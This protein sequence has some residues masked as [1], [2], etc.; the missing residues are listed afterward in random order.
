MASALSHITNNLSGDGSLTQG[1][2]LSH[3]PSAT[4]STDAHP[5]MNDPPKRKRGR[6]KGSTKKPDASP[7]EPK[8]K[9][10][11][12]RPRKD[13]LP[14]GSVP[15]RSPVKRSRLGTTLQD[16]YASAAS[17]WGA[18]S[19]I[20]GVS[21]P[22]PPPPPNI[23]SASTSKRTILASEE[24]NGGTDEWSE[25]AY[26]DPDGFLASL[27]NA[28]AAPNPT[29]A[30][31]PT[32]EEAFKM[33]LQSL[34]TNASQQSHNIPSLYSLLKT[35]WLPSSPAYFTIAASASSTRVPMEY[36]FLYWDPLPLLFNGIQCPYCP[37]FLT[38]KGRIR[39]GPIKIYDLEKPFFI[40]GCE[41]ACASTQC[42]TAT[43]PDGRKFASTDS[44]IM[45]ALPKGLRDEFPARLLHYENDAGSGANI[46]N[47]GAMG[48]SMSLWNMVVG[49]F[50]LGLRKSIVLQ[51]MRSIQMGVPELVKPE[52]K[53]EDK[54]P[55]RG[56]SSTIGDV[57][58]KR[59]PSE[60]NKDKKS[61]S[62]ANGSSHIHHAWN[63]GDSQATD[64]PNTSSSSYG[65]GANEGMG[66][67]EFVHPRRQSRPSSAFAQYPYPHYTYF[68]EQTSTPGQSSMGGTSG[69]RGSGNSQLNR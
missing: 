59:R 65:G 15:K 13:G 1:S 21:Y 29:S 30:T 9:R 39:S 32:V 5:P 58:E 12:G 53:D 61:G 40:I 26:T 19:S 52:S 14:A 63:I 38:N 28:L 66:A 25:N 23:I 37:G 47:W 17:Q 2:E 11:V 49:G 8:I 56:N 6:P 51:L 24:T 45:R 67:H 3:A 18:G 44:S 57:D 33:H 60:S 55:M 31:G 68:P 62:D 34:A 54:G 7:A 69:Q 42:I 46:W 10:P 22:P 20:S 43:C 35:F 50:K 27:L 48:V 4:A 16:E 36:K 41:Y 64:P